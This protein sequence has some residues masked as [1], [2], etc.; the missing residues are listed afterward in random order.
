MISHPNDCDIIL[1]ESM[2]SAFQGL[3]L[4]L[5]LFLPR[6]SLVLGGFARIEAVGSSSRSFA[7]VSMAP[8]SESPASPRH[9]VIAGA[10]VIGTSTAYYLAQNHGIRTT[11][12]DPTGTIAPAASGKAGGFLALDWNDGSPTQ[13]LTRRS[14]ALHQELADTLGAD[15]IQYRRLTC[16]AISV[17]PS[18]RTRRPGGKKLDEIEWADDSE[19]QQASASSSSSS[20]AAITGVRRLGNEDTIAQVHP[21]M[22][23][24]RMWEETSRPVEDGGIGSRL[25]KGTVVGAVHDDSGKKLVGIKLSDGTVIE[26][27]DALLFACGPW[28]GNIMKGVKYHSVII[29]T[30]RVLTQCV[31]FSGCGDPEVYVRPDSTAYCTGFPDS[32]IAVTERPGEESVR[33]DKISAIVDAVRE[34]SGSTNIQ[35]SSGALSKDPV[36]EQSCYLPTTDDGIPVMG[37]LP[38]ASAGGDHCYIAA[39]HTCWGILLGPASGESMASLIA[40]GKNTRYVNLDRFFDPS[41][42]TN[43]QLVPQ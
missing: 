3:T 27:A 15:S 28:T 6:N 12:V 22:L 34:A 29:P 35:E 39:G 11:L 16:S 41:R 31:F 10:G 30:D 24:N 4:I 42:F 26:D 38:E 19:T 36:V 13:Q 5:P 32:A 9:V 18:G 37:K 14:F 7:V 33:A 2:K 20:A 25:V 43:I 8:S 21:R 17:D 40:T 23:C 1:Q